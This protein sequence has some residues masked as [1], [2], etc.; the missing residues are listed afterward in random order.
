MGIYLPTVG[1][2][3]RF[4]KHQSGQIIATSHNRWAPK[5]WFRMENPLFRGNLGWW[6]NWDSQRLTGATLQGLVKYYNLARIPTVDGNQK[7]SEVSPVEVGSWN[8]LQGFTKRD[9]WPIN[10][11][12]FWNTEAE[13]GFIE[14]KY[15]AFR[16]GDW[17]SG[18]HHLRI[19]RLTPPKLGKF[20]LAAR[21]GW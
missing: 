17:T 21:I 19:W 18:H 16:F 11:M 10:S 3:P 4:L 2:D 15:F 7:S 1:I 14:L 5:S 20:R 12:D 9:F 6:N 13:N 8:Y